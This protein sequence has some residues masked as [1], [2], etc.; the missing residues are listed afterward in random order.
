[1]DEMKDE[2]KIIT[3]LEGLSDRLARLEKATQ[4]TASKA[5]YS[6]S[7]VAF[8]LGLAEWTVRDWCRD[9][10][11]KAAKN[12]RGMWTVSP[13]EIARLEREGPAPAE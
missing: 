3:L 10:K 6:V 11:I 1:M 9:G 2:S 8:R 4:A 7:D 13:E 12:S 5:G